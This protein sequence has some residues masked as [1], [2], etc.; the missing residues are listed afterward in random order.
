MP[1]KRPKCLSTRLTADEYAA[2][3]ALAGGATHR[4]VGAGAVTRRSVPDRP[5]KRRSSAK[6]WRFAPSS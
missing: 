5:P 3:D 4:H 1:V 6:S 2:L